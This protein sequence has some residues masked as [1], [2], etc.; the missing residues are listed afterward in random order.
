VADVT[1]E[2]LLAR[3][4]TRFFELRKPLLH[5]LMIGFEQGNRIAVPTGRSSGGST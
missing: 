2:H 4:I 5:L 1:G 3:L